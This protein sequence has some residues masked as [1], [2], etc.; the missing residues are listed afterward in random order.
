MKKV[1]L[2]KKLQL[3][4]ET[5]AKLQNEDMNNI[6][7]GK[8]CWTFVGN[9]SANCTGT[10]ICCYISIDKLCKTTATRIE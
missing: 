10:D 3:N 4:K 6:K 8:P 2:N 1:Q 5:I 7:G 9:C